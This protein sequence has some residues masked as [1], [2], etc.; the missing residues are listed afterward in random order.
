MED[1]YLH[2]KYFKPNKNHF[3][4]LNLGNKKDM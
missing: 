2:P 4:K 1:T 3:K